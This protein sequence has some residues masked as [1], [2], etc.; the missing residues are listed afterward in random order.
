MIYGDVLLLVNFSMDLLSLFLTSKTLNRKINVG[1]LCLSAVI[2]AVYSLCSLFIPDGAAVFFSGAAVALLMILLSFGKEKLLRSVPVFLAVNFLLGGGITALSRLLGLHR[3]A[4]KV[5]YGGTFETLNGDLPVPALVLGA[6]ACAAVSYGA[7]RIFRKSASKRDA[8][9]EVRLNGKEK[10]LEGFID[11][12]CELRDPLTGKDALIVKF[13]VLREIIPPGCLS[14]FRDGSFPENRTAYPLRL[15]L[16]PARGIGGGQ[17]LLFGFAADSVK[18]D[19]E[20]KDCVVAVDTSGGDF[21]GKAALIPSS[22][23]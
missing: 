19:G 4:A 13:S 11:T 15:R 6:A 23:I 10:R 17:T 16:I 22:L 14:L 7:G 21:N 18:I 20:E 3:N 12:G 2:G 9:I 5:S 1:K 8:L